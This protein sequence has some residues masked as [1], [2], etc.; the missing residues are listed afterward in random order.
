MGLLGLIRLIRLIRL[1]SPIHDFPRGDFVMTAR[2]STS[3]EIW[4]I[5]GEPWSAGIPACGVSGKDR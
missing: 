4:Q 3:G 5:G 2:L 1:T